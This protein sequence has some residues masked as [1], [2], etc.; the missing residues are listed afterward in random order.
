VQ[1]TDRDMQSHVERI[2]FA[3]LPDKLLLNPFS[4][5][6]SPFLVKPPT[7]LDFTNDPFPLALLGQDPAQPSVIGGP[8][9]DKVAEEERF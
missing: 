3:H 5:Q 1:A 9:K 4:Y 6:R 7:A 8:P 2:I